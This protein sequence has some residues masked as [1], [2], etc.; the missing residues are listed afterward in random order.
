MLFSI[1]SIFS[2]SSYQDWISWAAVHAAF[3]EVDIIQARVEVGSIQLIWWS[4]PVP[5]L[6]YILLSFT[7]G[8]EIRD[9][10]KWVR[11]LLTKKPAPAPAPLVLLPTQ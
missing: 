2:I 6:L 10:A 4:T 5:S 8:E 1:F 11:V 9:T 7:I 3:K